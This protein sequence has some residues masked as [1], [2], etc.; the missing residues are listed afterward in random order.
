[1]NSTQ[2]TA[3]FTVSPNA[4]LVNTASPLAVAQA[5]HFLIRHPEQ[6]RAIGAAGRETVTRHFHVERQM[7]QY[8]DLYSA[9]HEGKARRGAASP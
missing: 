3:P 4:V 9:L 2:S 6:R 5:V 8:S 7:R 1:M